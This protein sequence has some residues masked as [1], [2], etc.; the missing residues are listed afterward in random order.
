MFTKVHDAIQMYRLD[1][2]YNEG[3]VLTPG[4]TNLYNNLYFISMQKRYTANSK[5]HYQTAVIC[6]HVQDGITK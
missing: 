2:H 6:L 5:A 4:G 3:Y 1:H